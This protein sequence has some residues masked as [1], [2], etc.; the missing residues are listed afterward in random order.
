MKAEKSV[1]QVWG[2]EDREE[3]WTPKNANFKGKFQATLRTID[4]KK[5]KEK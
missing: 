4:L 2:Q 1:E 3:Q 5:N